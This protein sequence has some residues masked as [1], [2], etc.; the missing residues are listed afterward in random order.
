MKKTFKLQSAIAALTAMGTVTANTAAFAQDTENSGRQLRALEEIVVTGTRV[1]NR[2][3]LDT[4]SPVDVITSESLG[5]SGT[6]ELNQ[7][8]SLAVPSYNFPRPG[9][10]D[11]TD[12][13]RPATLRGL[14]PDQALVLVNSKRRHSASLVNVNGTVGRGSS[15]V[16]LNT[17]PIG[18]VDRIEVLRDGAAAQYGSDAIAGVINLRLRETR[19]G[20]EIT[21]SY[22]AND[23]SVK[24]QYR[25]VDCAR[26]HLA[27][28]RINQPQ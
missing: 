13:I 21:A 19:E 24:K 14:S 15:A 8:L 10:A 22:S 6:T 28:A 18:I 2:T 1:A 9:L 23:T 25:R 4:T 11:G 17:I 27:P 20:G 26:S 16:D 3:N 5:Q 7:A 12:T